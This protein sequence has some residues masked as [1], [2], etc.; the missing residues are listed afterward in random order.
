[1]SNRQQRQTQLFVVSVIIAALALAA[2]YLG[3][4]IIGYTKTAGQFVADAPKA[5]RQSLPQS[6]EHLRREYA[7][8]EWD[9]A[10][11]TYPANLEWQDCM[12]VGKR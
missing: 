7:E 12:G 11:E 9:D 4:C 2:L 1:M 8:D 6:C 3:V 10:L 5:Q